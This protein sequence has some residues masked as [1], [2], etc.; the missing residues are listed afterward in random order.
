M[1]RQQF[2]ILGFSGT[3]FTLVFA[4]VWVF[5]LYWVVVTSFKP[6]TETIAFPPTFFPKE[7]SLE[8]YT[9]ILQNS[10]ILS[11]YGNSLLTSVIITALVVLLA[12]MFAYALSQIE[13]PGKTWLYWLVLAGFMI[14]FQASLIPL[15]MLVNK[16]GL[17]NTYAGVILPQ[18]AAP[19]AVVIYK[20]FFDQVPK[21]LSEAAR[22]DGAS[23]F[24]I[25]FQIYLP[26]NLGITWALVIITFIGAWNNFFWPFIVTNSAAKMTIPVGITQ[27]QAAYGVAYSKTMATAVLAALPTVVAYLLFQRKVSEG[28][29]ATSGLK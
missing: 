11:W 29:M 4:I 12:L 17:V 22:L 19:I 24:R 10:P 26:L 8:A 20:Q 6:D 5:P 13:F 16:M 9:Y 7:W 2:S 18:L 1:K 28:V 21:E 25:L 23:E 14:P 3:L 27:V 15:F